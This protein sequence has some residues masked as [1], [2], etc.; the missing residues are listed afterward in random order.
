MQH[1]KSTHFF[2][3]L[4]EGN[5]IYFPIIKSLFHLRVPVALSLYVHNNMIQNI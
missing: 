1:F 5:F 4:L 2:F 3:V